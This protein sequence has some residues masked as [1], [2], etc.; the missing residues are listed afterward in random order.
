MTM[1]MIMLVILIAKTNVQSV[2]Y[3]FTI[4]NDIFCIVIIVN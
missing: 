4:L 2:N 3:H 1:I